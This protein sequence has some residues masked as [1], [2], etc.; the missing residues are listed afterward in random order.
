MEFGTQTITLAARLQ[1]TNLAQSPGCSAGGAWHHWLSSHL[2]VI[3]VGSMGTSA[4]RP[5]RP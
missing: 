2:S 1:G 5:E 3:N 4:D